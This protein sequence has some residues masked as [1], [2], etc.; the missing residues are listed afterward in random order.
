MFTPAVRATWK[1]APEP[2]AKAAKK[3]KGKGA[4]PKKVEPK[5]E[6]EKKV[7]EEEIDMFGSDDEDDEASFDALCKA[8]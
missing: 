4:E 3:G 8:K 5:K 7:E 1:A 2:K 6:V